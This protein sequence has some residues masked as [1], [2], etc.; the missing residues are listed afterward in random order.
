MADKRQKMLLSILISA[1]AVCAFTVFLNISAEK[2][3]YYKK[4]I[5]KLSLKLAETDNSETLNEELE[6]QL[7][8]LGKRIDEAEKNFYKEGETDTYRLGLLIKKIADKNRITVQKYRTAELNAK[9]QL[10]YTMSAKALDF[11]LFLRELSLEKK[12]IELA[13]CSVSRKDNS[14]RLELVLRL[15]PAV[16]DTKKTGFKTVT[17]FQPPETAAALFGY[18][19]TAALKQEN[20]VQPEQPVQSAPPVNADWIKYVGTITS[21][22]GRLLYFFK[23]SR[24]G[25]MIRLSLSA[26]D[27][28]WKMLAYEKGIFTL[29]E[30]GIR[31]IVREKQ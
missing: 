4:Q 14:D 8:A 11:A 27:R 19:K 9:L 6:Q 20:P 15:G 10:E 13:Y 2:S 23:N 22:E 28:D 29:E 25:R 30:N 12:K 31:Y 17:D 1:A 3:A 21:E 16:P 24:T 7:A 5:H 18:V 26:P